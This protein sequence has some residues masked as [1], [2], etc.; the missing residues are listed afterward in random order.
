MHIADP[1][2]GTTLGYGVWNLMILVT[3]LGVCLAAWILSR[4][5]RHFAP[6]SDGLG[7]VSEQWLAEHRLDRTDS[8]R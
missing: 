5:W 1:D 4:S 2:I 8:Q 3:A 7:S 6:Q